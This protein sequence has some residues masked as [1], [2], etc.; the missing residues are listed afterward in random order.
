MICNLFGEKI[1]QRDGGDD[2]E[3]IARKESG[4]VIVERVVK[5]FNGCWNGVVRL[6]PVDVE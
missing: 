1:E 6:V 5:G 2:E 3:E 4:C